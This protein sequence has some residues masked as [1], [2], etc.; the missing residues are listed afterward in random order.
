MHRWDTNPEEFKKKV[1]ANSKIK[2]VLLKENEA[3]KVI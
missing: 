1:E 2:V 3:F